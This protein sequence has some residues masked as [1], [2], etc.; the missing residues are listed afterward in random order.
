M[1]GLVLFAGVA[2][3]CSGSQS[4]SV[5]LKPI[6]ALPLSQQ[7]G[8]G[9]I[10]GGE[11][12]ADGEFPFQVSLRSI[13][14]L[15]ATHFCGGSI[16]SD[17]WIVT[18]AHCC[19]GKLPATMHVVAG[20]VKLN[21]F[22]NEEENRNLAQ[23]VSNPRYSSSNQEN[24][25]CLLQLKEALEWTE[26][27]QPIALP[28]FQQQTADGTMATVTGW[29]T[30]HEGDFNLPNELHKVDVPVIGDE[31][32]NAAYASAGYGT[33][34]SMI[35]AGLPEGGKDSCQGDSGGPFFLN[36][37]TPTLIGVVSWGIGC[38]RAG[39]PGV[40]TEVSYMVDWIQEVMATY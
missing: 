7:T 13:G 31:E 21:N 9:R 22:E 35:C 36:E 39:Y 17:T 19:A 24:D 38:A 23:I 14:A 20:G 34:E 15:G 3:F 28:E 32:C 26:F 6:P 33:S 27:V 40:Y 2:L 10:V 25:I 29:G 18:A 37:E 12:A 16:I 8:I 1:R 5:G 30:L 11:L 4:A